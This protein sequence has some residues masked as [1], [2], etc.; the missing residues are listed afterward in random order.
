[1]RKLFFR[2]GLAGFVFVLSVTLANSW[3]RKPITLPTSERKVI[4]TTLDPRLQ[5]LTETTLVAAIA[6][7][8]ATGRLPKSAQL[9]FVCIDNTNGDILAYV[10]GDV[11]QPN[12]RLDFALIETR[13]TGSVLK[14]IFFAIAIESGAVTIDETFSDV[15]REFPRLDGSGASYTFENYRGSYTGKSLT[16]EEAIAVSSNSAMLQA[17]HK[18]SR[19]SIERLLGLLGMPLEEGK[20]NINLLPV[21]WSPNLVEI[22]SAYSTLANDGVRRS[23]RLTVSDPVRTTPVFS[24]Q[25]SQVVLEGM[26]RVLTDGTGTKAKDLA[27]V[28]RAKTGSSYDSLAVLMTRRITVVIRIGSRDSNKDLR[29]SGGGLALPLAADFIRAARRIDSAYAPDWR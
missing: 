2:I 22:A 12:T 17:Y 16:I 4:Q 11:T 28:A 13:D 5:Q 8:R 9:S 3:R 23:P 19:Q 1:M 21:S 24:P 18:T 10:G 6:K 25:T 15:H 27:R 26:R 7:R 29:K 14:P 20:F